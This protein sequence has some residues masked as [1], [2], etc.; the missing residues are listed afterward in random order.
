MKSVLVLLLLYLP[1]LAQAVE[2]QWKTEQGEEMRLSQLKGKPVL[3][4][5]WASWCPPCRHEMPAMSRWARAHPEVR[6]VMVSLDRDMEDAKAFYARKN[7]TMPLYLGDQR[8]AMALGVRGLPTTIVI[9]A[10]GRLKKRHM[11]KLDWADEQVGRM[12]LKWL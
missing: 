9:D 2:Y 5:F 6:V 3:L 12:V 7:I 11:G 4:H 1:C 10:E 8:K